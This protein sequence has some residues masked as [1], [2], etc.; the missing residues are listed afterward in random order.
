VTYHLTQMLHVFTSTSYSLFSFFSF[1][2]IN[3]EETIIQ[4]IFPLRNLYQGFCQIHRIMLHYS[5]YLLDNI[6]Y[7]T[8]KW[9]LQKFTTL[10]K[11]PKV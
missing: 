1:K 4:G 5:K 10:K 8:L 7:N 6:A 3:Y 11:Q 9:M 2:D